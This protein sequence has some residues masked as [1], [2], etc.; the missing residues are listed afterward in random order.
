MP[1]QS[2]VTLTASPSRSGQSRTRQLVEATASIFERVRHPIECLSRGRALGD[3]CRSMEVGA[4]TGDRQERTIEFA[5]ND[6]LTQPL[7]DVG[8]EGQIGPGERTGD[9]PGISIS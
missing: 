5:E 3:V 1:R 4:S 9:P 6:R 2:G 7:F 8:S